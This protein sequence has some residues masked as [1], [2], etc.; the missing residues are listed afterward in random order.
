[1][2]NIFTPYTAFIIVYIDDVLVCSKTINQ[3][4]KHLEKFLQIIEKNGLAISASKML[5]F[6]TKIHFLGHDI[7]QG[8][9][10]PIQRS[11][12]FADKFPDEIKDKK[13]LQ[14]F[15]GCL[16]YVSDFFPHLKHYIEDLETTLILGQMSMQPFSNK[17]KNAFSPCNACMSPIPRHS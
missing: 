12:A 11:L 2:N 5:L 13:Q 14:R 8:S 9:I 4:F 15:L 17:L 3:H 1:M 7:F 16:N 6:Q 10:R